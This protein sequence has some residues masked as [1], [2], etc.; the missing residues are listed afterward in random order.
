MSDRIETP[1][2]ACHECWRNYTLSEWDRLEPDAEQQE[3]KPERRICSCGVVLELDREGLDEL[4][5]TDNA[6]D[7]AEHHPGTARVPIAKVAT[8]DPGPPPPA[9]K[10]KPKAKK[11]KKKAK[12]EPTPK[13]QAV[14]LNATKT[15]EPDPRKAQTE[16]IVRACLRR[17]APGIRTQL[18]HWMRMCPGQADEYTIG[19]LRALLTRERF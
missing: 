16:Q 11:S 15:P 19:E 9:K 3:G 18:V 1:I 10:S 13:V 12:T 8:I 2:K 7:Y 6:A 4:D 5:L 17:I 14:E